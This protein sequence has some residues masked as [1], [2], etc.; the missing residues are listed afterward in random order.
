MLNLVLRYAI[1]GR[2]GPLTFAC[3]E[4]HALRSRKSDAGPESSIIRQS[5]FAV[6]ADS[7]GIF[8]R[9]KQDLDFCN[10]SSSLHRQVTAQSTSDRLI[11]GQDWTHTFV[12][13]MS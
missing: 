11:R 2:A 13:A 7:I 6:R 9:L 10:Q 5:S 3:E 4:M 8:S 12:L 1:C